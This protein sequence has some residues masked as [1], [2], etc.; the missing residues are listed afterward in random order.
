MKQAAFEHEKGQTS[1]EREKGNKSYHC[2][3]KTSKRSGK[4]KAKSGIVL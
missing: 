2:A 3:R 4:I 1:V